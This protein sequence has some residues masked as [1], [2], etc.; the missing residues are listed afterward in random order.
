MSPQ[1]SRSFPVVISFSN[2]GGWA[3]TGSLTPSDN[4]VTVDTD[5]IVDF[6]SGEATQTYFTANL[7]SGVNTLAATLSLTHPAGTSTASSTTAVTVSSEISTVPTL[8]FSGS[9]PATPKYVVDLGIAAISGT[10]LVGA[11]ILGYSAAT[12]SSLTLRASVYAGEILFLL[13][14]IQLKATGPGTITITIS[15]T[16]NGYTQ[17]GSVFFN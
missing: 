4:G 17:S 3:D 13:E 1:T 9:G 8:S 5:G 12:F 11:G 10:K 14:P 2:T 15:V 6:Y 16:T 7:L